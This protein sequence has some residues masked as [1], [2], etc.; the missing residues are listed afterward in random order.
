MGSMKYVLILHI[1]MIHLISCFL[2]HLVSIIND[3]DKKIQEDHGES[4]L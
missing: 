3:I 2:N 1:K 4:F